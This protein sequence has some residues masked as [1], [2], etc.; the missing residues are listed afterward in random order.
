MSRKFKA[1]G[2]V[3]VSLPYFSPS[4]PVDNIWAMMIAWWIRGKIIGTVVCCCVRQL[5]TMICTRIWTVLKDECCFRF[6]FLVWDSWSLTSLFCT[7]TA[8]SETMFSCVCLGLA[9]GCLTLLETL[10]ICW[11]YFFLLL[12]IYKVSG[13]FSA[14]VYVFVVNIS[15]SSCTSECISTKYFAVNQDQLILRLV[16]LLTHLLIGW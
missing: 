16:I 3:S 11:N 14:L 10:E 12:E 4:H 2:T 9:S 15:Y 1:K 13:K 5:Y 8:I 6:S 7:N